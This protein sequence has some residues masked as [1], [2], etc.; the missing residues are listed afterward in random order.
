MGEQCR[1]LDTTKREVA[2]WGKL[3]Q[4]SEGR[5]LPRGGGR[6]DIPPTLQAPLRLRMQ[7][8]SVLGLQR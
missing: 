2:I 5:L 4:L 1:R 3:V 6:H 8:L 7:V